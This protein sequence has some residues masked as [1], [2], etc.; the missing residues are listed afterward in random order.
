LDIEAEQEE[1]VAWLQKLV[2]ENPIPNSIVAFW[3]GI[4]KYADNGKEIPTIY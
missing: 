3:I 2:N 4:A 1:I